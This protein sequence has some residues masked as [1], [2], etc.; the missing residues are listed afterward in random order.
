MGEGGFLTT[1]VS[2][3]WDQLGEA[4]TFASA[5]P[6]IVVGAGFGLVGAAIGTF[7]RAIRVGGRRR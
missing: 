7:K 6:I 2:F 3:A 1:A 4:V 5:N